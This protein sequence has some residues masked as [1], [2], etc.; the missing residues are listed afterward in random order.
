MRI[1]VLGAGAVG[2]YFGGRLVQRGVDVTFLVREARQAALA[3]NGLTIE[4]PACGD[5][6]GPVRTV[7]KAA[8][9]GE[10]PFDVILFTCKAYDLDDAI[11]SIA[12]AVSA[13][14]TVLPL[15]NG[16]SHM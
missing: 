10:A 2:G 14:S 3:A 13:R 5:F 7:T 4:S 15:L 6:K 11:A 12:P 8:L 1:L 16:M 9:G